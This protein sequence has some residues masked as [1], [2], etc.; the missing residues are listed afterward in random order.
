MDY[1]APLHSWLLPLFSLTYGSSVRPPPYPPSPSPPRQLLASP[2]GSLP[3]LCLRLRISSSAGPKQE[4]IYDFWRMVWQENCFSIVMITK[5]V[6]VGRVCSSFSLFVPWPQRAAG[7]DG[8]R[9]YVPEDPF[10]HSLCI[11]RDAVSPVM[12]EEMAAAAWSWAITF[13]LW[14]LRSKVKALMYMKNHGGLC[15]D[16]QQAV[17]IVYKIYIQYMTHHILD[18]NCW[19]IKLELLKLLQSTRN[20]LRTE[21]H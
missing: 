15:E 7:E 21:P 10:Y 6:E 18:F 20:D 16:R 9:E 8:W 17:V 5:L 2:L 4:M 1:T 14:W 3:H 19:K 13:L 12:G 11:R